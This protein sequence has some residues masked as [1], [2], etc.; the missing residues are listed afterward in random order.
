MNQ[1]FKQFCLVLVGVLCISPAFSQTEDD[2]DKWMKSVGK[3]MGDLRK[4]NEAKDEAA[5]KAGGKILVEAFTNADK[6][7][8]K[9]KMNDATDWNKA[10]LTAAKAL[11]DGTG[12]LQAVGSTCKPCHDKYREKL[13]DGSYKL[14]MSH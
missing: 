5:L 1:L 10:T 2:L 12:G 3:A 7:W 8:A 14:K 11:A 6:F 9:H 4:A 13:A